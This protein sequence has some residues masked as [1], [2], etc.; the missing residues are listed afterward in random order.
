MARNLNI[1]LL[2]AV[3]TLGMTWPQARFMSTRVHDSDDPLLSIWRIS[4]IAHILPRDP[5]GVLNGNIFHPEKR[6][7]AYTDAVLLQGI[8]AAPF[9]WM[10]VPA[11]GV[12][13]GLLL[14][15]IALSGWG[16]F[17]YAA[18]ITGSTAGAVVA[19]VIFAF[20]PYRFDHYHHLEL[21]A[22]ALLPLTL[23]A[24]ERSMVSR[25]RRDAAWL[26]AA[27]VAQV[28]SGIYYAVFLATAMLAIV[29]IR[30]SR[31][32]PAARREWLRTAT[33]ALVA[34]VVAVAPYLMAYMANRTTLG[35][36]TDADVLL[37]S[38]TWPNYFAAT[39]ENAVHGEW[40]GPLGQSERRLFPGLIAVLLALIGMLGAWRRQKATLLI[41]GVIGA[42]ISFG[43]NNPLYEP[44][45]AV[46]FPYRGLRAP[47]RA[48]IL[49]FLAIA[50]LAAYGFAAL[51]RRRSRMVKA[52]GAT[53]VTAALLFEY[54]TELRS[55]LTIPREPPQVY[56]WLASQPPSVVA[57][58]PFAQSSEIH[59][60]SDGLYMFYSTYHWQPIVNGY[61]G[62][63]PR[64]FMELSGQMEHFPGERALTALKARGV[65]WI[66]VH[67]AGL[68]ADRYGAI[69]AAL[70]ARPD[71]EAM[72]QFDEVRGGSDMVFRLR[73]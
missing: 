68:G 39:P 66:V 18:R 25:T 17:L 55:W 71:I 37:Y 73:R 57:E 72:A 24:L 30:L 50:G 70:L 11:V 23:L 65:D 63:F 26:A 16:M 7:L 10:G 64:S 69:T 48:S 5:A 34:G 44:M 60:I 43:L 28:Y 33:P 36:R 8:A 62:F 6:T 51:G 40:S 52:L 32:E 38:A 3:L 19:G 59:A 61:S 4:W 20:V 46:L 9:I 35:E 1:L 2:F 41:A 14:A 54:R 47:A 22:T 42:F 13:N 53:A 49:V 58:V 15:S 45:R 31:M 27:F 29:P 12:Y 67:G 21:Q 56:R